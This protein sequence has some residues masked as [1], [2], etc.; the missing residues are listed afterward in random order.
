MDERVIIYLLGGFTEQCASYCSSRYRRSGLAFENDMPSNIR[1]ALS[2]DVKTTVSAASQRPRSKDRTG[3][4]PPSISFLQSRTLLIFNLQQATALS[5]KRMVVAK[6][7]SI[8]KCIALLENAHRDRDL[9]KADSSPRPS[10]C[11]S[12]KDSRNVMD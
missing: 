10:D 3:S 7:L 4:G 2:D 1:G 8:H 6:R 5:I 9:H 12:S 11:T